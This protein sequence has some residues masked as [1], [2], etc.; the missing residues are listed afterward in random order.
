MKIGQSSNRPPRTSLAILA[1]AGLLGLGGTAVVLVAPEPEPDATPKLTIV[2]ILLADGFEGDGGGG[3]AP[4]PPDF[5]CPPPPGGFSEVRKEWTHL[6]AWGN[7]CGRMQLC[8][9]QL[10]GYPQGQSY[11]A[12][13]GAARGTFVT[14]PFTPNARQSVNLYF[15]QVQSRPQIG[16]NQRPA[17]G[18]FI[19]VSPCPGDFRP[20]DNASPN[21]FLHSACRM[22]ENSGSL[23]WTSAPGT[24]ACHAPP[25]APLFLNILPADPA[26]GIQP[27]ESSCEDVPATASGCDVGAVVS[28][29][30]G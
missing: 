10:N 16:Y 12:P 29:G 8:E 1:A 15:D 18:M 14:V 20:A 27:G 4:V 30:P 22:Y 6:F 19:T 23:I 7:P 3:G 17:R 25:W 21:P 2:E 26:D 5:A 28:T 11:P 24:S 13:I 9:R